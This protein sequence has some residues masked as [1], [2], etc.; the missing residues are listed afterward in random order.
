MK[1]NQKLPITIMAY[2]TDWAEGKVR[3]IECQD[4]RWIDIKDIKH[5][6]FVAGAIPIVDKLLVE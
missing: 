4:S 2:L 1:N 5:Y 6:D 3:N